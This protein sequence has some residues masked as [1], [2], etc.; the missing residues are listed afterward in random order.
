MIE[1][2][3]TSFP[4]Q[5]LDERYLYQA[6][7]GFESI[8]LAQDPHFDQHYRQRPP[9]SCGRLLLLECSFDLLLRNKAH[10]RQHLT[11]PDAA[12]K[13]IGTDDIAILED[14]L[15]LPLAPLDKQ[16]P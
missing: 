15:A 2:K 10:L 6:L 7:Q 9:V 16:N 1:S 8:L 12:V 11:D 14:K 13:V 5:Y 4:G 3:G